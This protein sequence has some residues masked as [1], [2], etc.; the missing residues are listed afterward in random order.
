M[1]ASFQ[2]LEII[3]S[4]EGVWQTGMQK[5]ERCNIV[6]LLQ[7]GEWNNWKTH[8]MCKFMGREGPALFLYK[9]H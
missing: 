6:T 8:S 9:N 3:L 4:T 1:E 2:T 5:V 7:F